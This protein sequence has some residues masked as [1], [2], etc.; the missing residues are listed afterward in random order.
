MSS[1]SAETDLCLE[2]APAVGERGAAEVA[3]LRLLVTE[4][5]GGGQVRGVA[6]ERELGDPLLACRREGA[7]Q[8]ERLVA[9]EGIGEVAKV[10]RPDELLGR[11]VAH[12]PPQWL[13]LDARPEVPHRVHER[14]G[15]E[16]DHTLL[17]PEPT[18]LAVIGQSPPEGSAVGDHLVEVAAHDQRRELLDGCAAQVVAAP[19]GEGHA[20]TFVWTVG[21]EEHV[22]AGVVGIL[23]HRVGTG[24]CGGGPRA[25][26]ERARAG[27]AGHCGRMLESRA[28]REGV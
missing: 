18:Q 24:E 22:R 8:V 14:G 7:Q 26:V 16:V 15:R 20:D 19:D 28:L 25:Y 9:V 12:E 10:D 6:V 11:Q 17:R 1:A 2:A 23:V 27:D 4:P 3:H 21:R 13:L 5:A